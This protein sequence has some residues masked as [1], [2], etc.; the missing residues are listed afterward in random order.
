[1]GWTGAKDIGSGSFFTGSLNKIE[2]YTIT[3]TGNFGSASDSVTVSVRPLTI[4][5]TINN[6][7]NPTPTSLIIATSSLDRTQPIIPTISNIKPHPGD[8]IN[9]T[10]TYQN[11]STESISNLK[12]KVTLPSKVDHM[13]STPNNPS[14][15]ENT[16]TFNLGTLKKDATGKITMRAKVQE[17]IDPGTNLNFPAIL[18]YTD[19]SGNLQSAN[20][21]VSA[22]VFSN[23]LITPAEIIQ[24]IPLEG[25]V[26]NAE[27]MPTNLFEW[28]LFFILILILMLLAKYAFARNPIRSQD[29]HTNTPPPIH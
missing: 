7:P 6:K 2:T 1:V 19:F 23:V 14:I 9:Y 27:F 21:N 28:L 12:I 3:C 26:F 16:L 25:N 13:S 15:S 20:T 11:A 5:T 29:I 10:I 18:T 8:E 17:N 24:N 22:Q 4:T